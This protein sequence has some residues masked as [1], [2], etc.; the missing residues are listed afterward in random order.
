MRKCHETISQ[1]MQDFDDYGPIYLNAG[2]KPIIIPVMTDK[3]ATHVLV[4]CINHFKLVVN[5]RLSR[6]RPRDSWI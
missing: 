4:Q 5:R 2:L 6:D 3:L 1:C